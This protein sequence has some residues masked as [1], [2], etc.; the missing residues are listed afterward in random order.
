[1]KGPPPPPHEQTKNAGKI[2]YNFKIGNRARTAYLQ[3]SNR[4]AWLSDARCMPRPPVTV[5]GVAAQ[6]EI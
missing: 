1:M 5:V 2:G 4:G 6:G 3:V